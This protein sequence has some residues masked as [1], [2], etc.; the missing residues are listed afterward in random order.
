ML[1]PLGK[2]LPLGGNAVLSTLL[3][4]PSAHG[5]ME[6]ALRCNRDYSTGAHR[7]ISLTSLRVRFH[8]RSPERMGWR[9]WR[10]ARSCTSWTSS[11]PLAV[12]CR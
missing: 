10:W 5:T 11:C 6:V 2:R 7:E 4:R 3:A 8:C 9:R 12:R 1:H